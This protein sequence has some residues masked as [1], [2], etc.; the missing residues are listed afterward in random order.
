MATPPSFVYR[1]LPEG[2]IR[3]L[4]LTTGQGDQ[5]RCSLLATPLGDTDYAALSYT[6]GDPLYR[7]LSGDE[8]QATP[9]SSTTDFQILTDDGSCLYAS[10]NLLDALVQLGR[11]GRGA[12]GGG[13]RGGARAGAGGAGGGGG[14]GGIN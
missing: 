12:G 2:W 3:L 8:S 1:P 11:A 10:E 7:E 6:W 4:K 5:F 13:G 9:M 14:A